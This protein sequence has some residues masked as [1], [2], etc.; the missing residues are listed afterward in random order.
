MCQYRAADAK[1]DSHTIPIRITYEINVF[2]YN[3]IIYVLNTI[4]FY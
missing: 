3:L 4:V 2:S 1:L